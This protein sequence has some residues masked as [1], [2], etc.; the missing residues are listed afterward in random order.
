MTKTA[1]DHIGLDSIQ[2]AQLLEALEAH[3]SK[4]CTAILD[5]MDNGDE[6]IIVE[7]C[8]V[9]KL[10]LYV[11]VKFYKRDDRERMFVISAHTPRKW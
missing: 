8:I 6:V 2:K 3:V 10:V 5:R 4:D 9:G 11:K 7:N 1:K